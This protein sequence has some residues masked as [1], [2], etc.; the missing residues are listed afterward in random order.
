MNEPKGPRLRQ[1]TTTTKVSLNTHN[2]QV[3]SFRHPHALSTINIPSGTSLTST[4]LLLAFATC[5][6]DL[7]LLRHFSTSRS[8]NCGGWKARVVEKRLS[9]SLVSGRVGSVVRM[10]RLVYWKDF[11]IGIKRRGF[12]PLVKHCSLTQPDSFF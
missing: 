5:F 7:H 12:D 9:C 4:P 3:H 8:H 6:V 2:S 10:L 1:P 11:L